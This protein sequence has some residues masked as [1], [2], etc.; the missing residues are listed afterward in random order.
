MRIGIVCPY[1]FDAPGGVQ[2]H[3]RDLAEELIRRGHYVSV[4]A[5]ADGVEDAPEWLVSA[6]SAVSI[7]FNGSVARLSFGPIVASRTK[8]WLEEGDFDVVHI[9]EPETP[10]VGLL[11]LRRAQVP[12]VGTFHAALDRSRV[13]ALT[14]G[15]LQPSLEKIAARIAVSQEARRTLIEHHSGDAVIIPNGVYTEVFRDAKPDPRWVATEDRPV[16]VFLGRLD[17]SRKGLPVFAGAVD[18]V[19]RK[20]PGTRFLVAGRGDAE[21]LTPLIKKH[22]ESVELL[23]EIT[24]QEKASLLAGATVYVAP[25]LGGESFGIVLVEAMAAGTLVVAS[26]IAAFEAVLD[27]GAS[28]TLFEVGSSADLAKKLNDALDHPEEAERLALAGQQR[29]AMYDWSTVTDQVLAVYDAVVPF[30]AG[31]NTGT[32]YERLV[33]KLGRGESS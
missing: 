16:I 6:G 4:L 19:L 23:G 15:A 3:I 8:K 13:R 30:G 29:S 25:Q 14:S 27:N 1:S 12:V 5:P 28:G 18:E 7:P 10:S 31:P 21:V 24:D 9:H 2:F 26:N 22:P 20:D 33:E 11:A 32:P 17:E